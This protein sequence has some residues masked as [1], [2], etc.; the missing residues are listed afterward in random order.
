MQ[1]IDKRITLHC[2]SNFQPPKAIRCVSFVL[3]SLVLLTAPAA[4]LAEGEQG[5]EVPQKTEASLDSG[6]IKVDA[7]TA[8][9]LG[10]K[11]EPV[12]RQQLAVGIKATGQ[13]ET[14]PNQQVQ[15]TTPITG[16]VVNLLAQPGDK[17]SKGQTVAV[18]SSPELQQLRVAA[19][20][21]RA[22]AEPSLQKALAD[23]RLAQQ[24]YQRQQTLVAADIK[25]AQS[26]LAFAQKRYEGYKYLAD[27]GASP[28]L[29]A[30]QQEA[31]LAQAKAT[32]AQA[33]SRLPVL[34]AQDQLKNAQ[35]GVAAAQSQVR[36]ASAAYQ[37]R[38]QQLGNRANAQGLVTVA[39]PISGRVASRVI[40]L[41][42][43]VTA[44]AAS[45]PLMT[46]LN[47]SKVY[48]TAN[49]YEK[50]LNFVHIGQQVRVKSA[51]LPNRTFSG[52][53]TVIGTVVQSNTRVMPV[54]AELD[55][56][57]GLLKPGMFAELE[58]LTA[59]TPTAVLAIPTGA[60]VEANGKKIV[61][62]QNGDGDA[63]QPVEV[64]LGQTSGD[65]VEVKSGLKD[66]D[67]IV[68]QQAPQLYAQSLLGGGQSGFGSGDPDGG[69]DKQ[70]Q[71]GT[72]PAANQDGKSSVSTP[73]VTQLPWWLVLPVGGGTFAAGF[74]VSRRTKPRMMLQR[75]LES[76]TSEQAKGN[77]DRSVRQISSH[78]EN[79]R[80]D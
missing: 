72:Q 31:A 1:L 73:G 36:L 55:N 15:L 60:V 65:M 22:A 66:G 69:G 40:T 26:Q 59:R 35:A 75:D 71:A 58:V 47:D 32:L 42:E 56:S 37:A 45:Q 14:L 46:I 61:Y 2:S 62:V 49:I 29:L 54:Q 51:S 39:A 48:A 13:I 11:V 53:I 52:R 23:L 5:K 70:D 7:E 44:E 74:W 3:L 25:Q 79:H 30:Q 34:Q 20:Q 24:N 67:R 12:T 57:S 17:V 27:T 4:V 43:T 80:P 18:L 63:Y 50:E 6:A 19:V 41:G 64:T 77:A 78:N 21:A 38:L 8:K 16:T 9:G 33:E 68:T 28:P 10:I 76:E